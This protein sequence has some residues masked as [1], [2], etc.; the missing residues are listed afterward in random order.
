MM[1]KKKCVWEGRERFKALTNDL[2]NELEDY[3]LGAHRERKWSSK[4]FLKAANKFA[5]LSWEKYPQ[6][7]PK[8]WGSCA[9]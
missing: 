8:R 4:Y 6:R 1:T 5:V 3:R 2:I 9:G 7:E